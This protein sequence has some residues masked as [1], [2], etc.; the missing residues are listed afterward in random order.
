MATT[1]GGSRWNDEITPTHDDWWAYK[2]EMERQ[3][4][5][6]D[7]DYVREEYRDEEDW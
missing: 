6:T 4:D 1:L 2:T 7:M 5:P 3:E